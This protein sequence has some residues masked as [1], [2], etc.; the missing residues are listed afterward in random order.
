MLD[1]KSSKAI[2]ERLLDNEK[3]FSIVNSIHQYG[4]PKLE[5]EKHFDSKGIDLLK[6]ENWKYS[7]YKDI[8]SSQ[9]RM[10]NKK[11]ELLCIECVE[12]LKLWSKPDI[13]N[14]SKRKTYYYLIKTNLIL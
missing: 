4:D 2:K 11:V 13:E 14:K 3:L 1:N 8:K 9:E 12:N 7:T 10:K 5:L 6:D